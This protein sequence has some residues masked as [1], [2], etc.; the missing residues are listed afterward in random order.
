MISAREIDEYRECDL[1]SCERKARWEFTVKRE[2]RR[3]R[4]VYAC[5]EHEV[6]GF[7]R[8]TDLA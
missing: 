6:D 1:A 2:G 7:R 3:P 4:R 8:A 5:D